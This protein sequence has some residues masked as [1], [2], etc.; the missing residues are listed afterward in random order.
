M[1]PDTGIGCM[2][3]LY[4]AAFN[5][6]T[7]PL[8]WELLQRARYGR[9]IA[10]LTRCQSTRQSDLCRYVQSGEGREGRIRC[11]KIHS[12]VYCIP[13]IA[14]YGHSMAVSPMGAV[15]A[16]AQTE[17]SI[18]HATLGRQDLVRSTN[19]LLEP[20]IMEDTR[21]GIPL[22]PQRRFDLYPDISRVK[23]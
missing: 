6:H 15:I 5:T 8:H 20:Q 16:T 4:P 13:D 1:K 17:E 7:G 12:W 14:K 21:A 9:A 18:V 3:M 23:A 10:G 19:T 22:L 2:A 11:G